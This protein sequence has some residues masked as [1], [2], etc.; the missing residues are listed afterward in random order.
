MRSLF[1]LENGLG[2]TF[3]KQQEVDKETLYK[4]KKAEKVSVI[5]KKAWL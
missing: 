1:L 4:N 3:R 5:K 2:V